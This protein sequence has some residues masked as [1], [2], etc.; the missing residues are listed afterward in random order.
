MRQWV[1][2]TSIVVSLLATSPLVMAQAT[3]AA[4]A[5]TAVTRPAMELLLPT[6]GGTGVPA[7]ND[8]NNPESGFSH[9]RSKVSEHFVLFWHKEYGD[10]PKAN[11]GNRHFDADEI[12]KEVERF[13][14]FYVG[15]ANFPG[16]GSASIQ[17]DFRVEACEFDSRVAG[18]ELPVNYLG[19]LV[20][21]VMPG[22]DATAQF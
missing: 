16:G 11:T 21:I 6:R 13:Y 3:P 18:G 10:D 4:P 5:A 1:R 9:K 20:A 17:L 15:A 7:N 8:Y 19:S 2:Q 12:I 22:F 14:T